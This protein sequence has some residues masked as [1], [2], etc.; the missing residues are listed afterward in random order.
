MSTVPANPVNFVDPDG[1]RWINKN[2]QV[3][4]NQNGISSHASYEEIQLADEMNKTR[5][6]RAQL[7]K[8]IDSNFDVGG[9]V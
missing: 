8:L 1:E 6:G 2:G 9:L 5:T 7:K 3:V 4:Y